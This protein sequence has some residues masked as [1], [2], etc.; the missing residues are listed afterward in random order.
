MNIEDL[1]TKRDELLRRY[2]QMIDDPNT[3]KYQLRETRFLIA[4]I[5]RQLKKAMKQQTEEEESQY[6]E[7]DSIIPV[8]DRKD[9]IRRT[10]EAKLMEQRRKRR[11]QEMSRKQAELFMENPDKFPLLKKQHEDGTYD[12]QKLVD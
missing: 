6:F 4:N 5:E 7:K 12:P 10:K 2:E 3:Q 11:Y 9:F 8:E 1:E